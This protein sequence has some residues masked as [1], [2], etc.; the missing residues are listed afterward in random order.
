V[1]VVPGAV[2]RDLSDGDQGAVEGRGDLQVHARVADLA[3]EQIR[4]RG[5]VPRRA[6]RA[7]DQHRS[8]A[9]D[10]CRVGY[11][12]GED[13]TDHWAQQIPAAADRGLADSEHRAGELLGH[14]VPQQ[15]HHHRHRPE[16]SQR[17]RSATR[18]ELVAAHHMHS[19]HQISELPIVQPCHSLTPQQL[20]ADLA[21]C[22]E[23]F[24]Q[25]GKS[26]C[27]SSTTRTHTDIGIQSK[28]F[29]GNSSSQPAAT[30][31]PTL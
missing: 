23:D 21:R 12:L 26:C 3:G 28:R 14:V 10:L 19:R 17:D 18:D 31:F 9:G 11:D 1:R 7:V 29:T 15:A 22:P 13:L 24:E 5:P 4:H 6:D 8:G 25:D 20:F 27:F 30:H 16:Q 2:N